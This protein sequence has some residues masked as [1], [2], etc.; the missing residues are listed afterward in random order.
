METG[1]ASGASAV[2]HPAASAPAPPPSTVHSA[3][4]PDYLLRDVAPPAAPATM[5][6]V[7]A[8]V[9]A[10]APEPARNLP[11]IIESLLFAADEP[12]TVSQIARAAN[13][14]R[15]AVEGALDE[16]SATAPTRGLRLQ[17]SGQ[18]LR[19]VTAAEAAPF[20]RRLLGLERPNKLSKAALETLAIIAYQQPVTR[21]AIERL[22][23]VCCDGPLATLRRRELVASIGQSDAPGRPHL[24]AT[25]PA[26]LAH[27]GLHDLGELPPLPGLSG[28]ATQPALPLPAGAESRPAAGADGQAAA[29]GA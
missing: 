9:E 5:P 18:T 6:A 19:L 26:F 10:G 15:D 17:R 20:I 24:W 21:G 13:V 12:P 23:G 25:T 28:P 7:L 29:G 16:L 8:L 11:L 27:F 14:S 22:R 4:P 3:T 1:P 2:A